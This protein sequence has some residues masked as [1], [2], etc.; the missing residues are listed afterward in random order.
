MKKLIFLTILMLGFSVGFGQEPGQKAEPQKSGVTSQQAID[1]ARGFVLI[2]LTPSETDKRFEEFK[3]RIGWGA[4]GMVKTPTGRVYLFAFGEATLSSKKEPGWVQ[5]RILALGEA[6]LK[7]RG[8]M[9]KTIATTIESGQF[10]EQ[11]DGPSAEIIGRLKGLKA[12]AERGGKAA[13]L[14]KEATAITA[15]QQVVG[16]VTAKTIEGEGA[17][18]EYRIIRILMWSP[19]LFDLAV[20][21]LADSSN[22]LPFEDMTDEAEQQIP[23]DEAELLNEVGA[24]V[25]LNKDGQRFYVAFGQAEPLAENKSTESNANANSNAAANSNTSANT[26]TKPAAENKAAAPRAVA[27]AKERAELHAYGQLAR[28]LAASVSLVK[29]DQQS[30]LKTFDEGGTAETLTA[31]FYQR[32]ESD[33]KDLKTSGTVTVRTWQY[34]HPDWNLP[35]VGSVV[36][37]TPARQDAVKKLGLGQKI[38]PKATGQLID[39]LTKKYGVPTPTTNGK[40]GKSK[41]TESRDPIIK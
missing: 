8:D 33:S 19:V 16:A 38:D 35:V 26:N 31:A 9:A 13:D 27:L 18:G 24:Q 28:T 39:M 34:Q 4:D 3:K 2:E 37:W 1:D 14:Y 17:D 15:S 6:E 40:S 21:T 30:V 36:A 29:E 12:E 7:A 5:K 41:V 23:T 32:I 11:F 22:Y 25:Y 10:F 20:N